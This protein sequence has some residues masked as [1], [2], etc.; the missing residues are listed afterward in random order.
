MPVALDRRLLS[1][2]ETA[3]ITPSVRQ[4]CVQHLKKKKKSRKHTKV[5]QKN[6]S[7]SLSRKENRINEIKRESRMNDLTE[8]RSNTWDSIR[9]SSSST[10]LP[11]LPN[12][13]SSS[14]RLVTPTRKIPSL[15]PGVQPLTVSE[16]GKKL[17]LLVAI[18]PENEKAEK[19]RFIRAN[20]NYNPFF[21]YRFP[22]DPEVLQKL[23]VPSDRFMHQV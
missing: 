14:P 5:K 4:Q 22:A 21:L 19:E 8:K 9:T 10:K 1:T 20:Y 23:G 12:Q 2:S 18:K 6:F 11:S 16:G 7:A 3:I 17:P 13:T 15:P